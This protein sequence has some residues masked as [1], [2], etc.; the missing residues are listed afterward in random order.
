MGL[1]SLPFFKAKK[2]WQ[3]AGGGLTSDS[4]GG[5]GSLPIATTETLGAVRVGNG[6]EVDNTGTLSTICHYQTKEFAT[7][8]KW[9]DNKDVFGLVLQLDTSI[10]I[11]EDT[12][13]ELNRVFDIDQPLFCAY[14]R[15]EYTPIWH[16]LAI[17]YNTNSKHLLLRSSFP[18]FSTVLI[19]FEYVK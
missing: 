9:I 1:R 8:K 2:G 15:S 16:P 3:F 14:A 18:N 7:G 19:Y 10:D 17:S 13:V 6:L 11:V 4:G 5:G 12:W